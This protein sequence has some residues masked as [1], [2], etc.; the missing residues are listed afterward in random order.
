[1]T[2]VGVKI[3]MNTQ[4]VVHSHFYGDL[5]IIRASSGNNTNRMRYATR[6]YA[7]FIAT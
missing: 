3:G 4:S 5:A 1:M 6:P 7:I 2:M